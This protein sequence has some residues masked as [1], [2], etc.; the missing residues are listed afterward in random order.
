ME[1]AAHSRT[2][3]PA[4]AGRMYDYYL[5]GIHNFPA[6]QEAARR[7]IEQF[8]HVPAAARSNRAFLGRAVRHLAE[9]GVRQFLDIGSGIPTRGN[10]HEVVQAV[11]PETRVVYVDI[12]PVAVSE[13]LDLLEG[14]ELATSILADLRDPPAILDH[15]QLRKILD[16]QQPTA[17]VL[18]AVVH[19]VPDDDEAYRVVGHLLGALAPGSYLA[20]AHG[21]P[22]GFQTDGDSTFD[23]VADVYK[24]QTTTQTK[25][26]TKEEVERFFTG[27]ELLEPGVVW[28]PQWRPDERH[29]EELAATPWLSCEYA[30]VGRKPV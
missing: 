19:F 23:N 12:D 7:I 16:L 17:L 15:P 10:V 26:R 28:P 25:L 3:K 18:A 30:G 4:T 8:P 1:N 20:L 22:E 9:I 11:A 21:A 13:G 5:G 27:L 6:D 14:N 29:P 24:R 2:Q